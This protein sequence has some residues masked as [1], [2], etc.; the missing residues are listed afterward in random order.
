ML[1]GLFQ[2]VEFSLRMVAKNP[3]S[4]P[5]IETENCLASERALQCFVVVWYWS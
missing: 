3:G 4:R 1:T 2:G 5:E